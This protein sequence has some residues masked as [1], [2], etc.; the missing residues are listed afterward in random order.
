MSAVVTRLIFIDVAC[1]QCEQLMEVWEL[2]AVIDDHALTE[3]ELVAVCKDCE[4]MCVVEGSTH[5]TEEQWPS[6]GF[7]P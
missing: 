5:R 6:P 3:T 2:L 4:Y 7:S 1:P